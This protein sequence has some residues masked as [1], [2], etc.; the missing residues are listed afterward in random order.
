MDTNLRVAPCLRLVDPTCPP[1][2]PTAVELIRKLGSSLG[3]A[4]V[5][6]VGYN[7]FSDRYAASIETTLVALRAEGVDRV[8]WLTLR[9]VRHPYVQMNNDIEDAAARHRELAIIDWNLYSRSHPDWFQDDGLHLLG[10]GAEAMATLIREKLLAAGVA[11]PDVYVKTKG[12]EDARRGR[13]YRAQLQPGGGRPPY[14]WSLEGRLPSGLHLR[15]TGL[16]WGVAHGRIGRYAVNVKV[17][18][19]VGQTEVQTLAIRL[20]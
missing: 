10:S 20:R 6:A 17:K 14:T 3:A 2:P 1:N 15:P 4:V 5:I 18:D 8:F 7:E 9:A 13:L 11:V 16:L 12:L 19:G